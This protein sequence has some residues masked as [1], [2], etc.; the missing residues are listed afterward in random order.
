M[1]A[2]LEEGD[3]FTLNLYNK[4]TPHPHLHSKILGFFLKISLW[5]FFQAVYMSS[6]EKVESDF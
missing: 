5:I 6:Q 1:F 3:H 4:V 2:G